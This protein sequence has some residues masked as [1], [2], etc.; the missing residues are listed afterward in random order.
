MFFLRKLFLLTLFLMNNMS[1]SV[2]YI[3]EV[4]NNTD[5][6][7]VL[8]LCHNIHSLENL[9]CCNNAQVVTVDLKTGV[10][11]PPYMVNSAITILPRTKIIITGWEMPKGQV[12]LSGSQARII[13]STCDC[14]SSPRLL[15]GFR[16]F[17]DLFQVTEKT[18]QGELREIILDGT[19]IRNIDFAALSHTNTTGLKI[20]DGGHYS[21]GINQVVGKIQ[22]INNIN[23]FDFTFK[24]IEP[25]KQTAFQFAQSA[26]AVILTFSPG[27]LENG[28]V[29]VSIGFEKQI[30][31]EFFQR[32][33]N[34]VQDNE[35]VNA[36]A[37]IVKDDRAQSISFQIYTDMTKGS[38]QKLIDKF[39]LA[40]K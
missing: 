33:F 3:A 9:G 10:N 30:T 2:G 5:T 23:G 22:S 11:K 25:S 13:I 37:T 21:V 1:Y 31:P 7:L 18:Y 32:F 35:Y 38:F 29:N 4:I 40:T 36:V 39:N 14:C 8:G 34:L 28:V 20:I 17:G 6:R 26:K 27:T 19:K 15:I 24:K 16:Q 12:N